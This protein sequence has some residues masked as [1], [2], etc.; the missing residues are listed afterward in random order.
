LIIWSVKCFSVSRESSSDSKDMLS[1][2][3]SKN[4]IVGEIV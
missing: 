1:N 4:L 3:G 2:L